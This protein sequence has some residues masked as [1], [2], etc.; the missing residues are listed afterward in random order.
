MVVIQG[1]GMAD[2]MKQV[3]E[4]ARAE[5]P[6]VHATQAEI[7]HMTSKDVSKLSE[8][9]I[10]ELDAWMARHSYLADSKV[11]SATP[12]KTM[13]TQIMAEA[14]KRRLSISGNARSD[15]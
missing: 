11:R 9:E 14:A 2:P 8:Q 10:L 12:Y 15:I 6:V 5:R 7:V 3:A 13:K 4:I 1:D